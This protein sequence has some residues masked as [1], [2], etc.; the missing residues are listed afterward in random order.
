MTSSTAD[1][2]VDGFDARVPRRVLV[3]GRPATIKYAGGVAGTAGVWYGVDWDDGE[4]KHDGS[5]K[6]TRYFAA[7]TATSGS[8]IRPVASKITE[9][10]DMLSAIRTKYTVDPTLN[11]SVGG[12]VDVTR[13]KLGFTGIDV[14]LVGFNKVALKQTVDKLVEVNLASAPVGRLP[15]LPG[16]LSESLARVAIMDLSGTLFA[17]WAE[18]AVLC[19]ALPTLQ[20][21][22]LNRTRLA[23][24]ESPADDEAVLGGGAFANVRLLT[25]NLTR[26]PSAAMY[27]RVLH[28]FTGLEE[29]HIGFNDLTELPKLDPARA[30]GLAHLNVQNNAL[31]M[32]ALA[33]LVPLAGLRHLNL[34]WNG[35]AEIS[36]SD[37]VL[38]Q[39]EVLWLNHNALAAW[40]AVDCLARWTALADLRL[41]RNP[42]YEGATGTSGSNDLARVHAIARLPGLQRLNQSQIL[43]KERE[44]AELYF[45][46]LAA[47][48]ILAATSTAL[49]TDTTADAL[50][51]AMPPAVR[52]EFAPAADLVRRGYELPW[53]APPETEKISAARV[54]VVRNGGASSKEF[55][56]ALASTT[57]LAF[58]AVVA[59]AFRVPPRKLKL[60]VTDPDTGRV[61]ELADDAKFLTYYNVADGTSVALA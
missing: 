24:P 2:A 54:T 26:Y 55:A 53:A 48:A 6:G 12:A 51:A 17:T 20:S 18:M 47:D 8:F 52:A 59:R 61:E 42:V 39:V 25:L 4:G 37:P 28:H 11:A 31:T 30:A 35:I 50:L 19:G 43:P 40:R 14:E 1:A 44:G 3:T 36:G 10:G 58:K 9:A 45:L 15:E 56:V 27:A 23:L 21:L 13:A 22:H 16:T 46:K 38:P 57:V 60:R 32:A 41:A 34:Q 49:P 33:P 5:L 29:L 7:T